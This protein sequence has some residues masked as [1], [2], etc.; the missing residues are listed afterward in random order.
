MSAR[1]RG[2]EQAQGVGETERP[3]CPEG[4]EPGKRVAEVSKGPWSLW[5]GKSLG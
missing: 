1:V 3:I 5:S 4:S 2:A